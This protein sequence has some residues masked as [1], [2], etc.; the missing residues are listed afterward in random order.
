MGHFQ[1]NEQSIRELTKLGFYKK[2]EK[3]LDSLHKKLNI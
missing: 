2:L 3:T 1:L